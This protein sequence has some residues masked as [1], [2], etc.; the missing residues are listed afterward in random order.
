[1][2]DIGK[3]GGRLTSRQLL[4]REISALGFE[5][6]P[7]R[8]AGVSLVAPMAGIAANDERA[9]A[10][11]RQL[12]EAVSSNSEVCLRVTDAGGGDDAIGNWQ[13]CCERIRT[14]TDLRGVDSARLAV[15]MPAHLMPA[16][17]FSLISDSTLGSGP[18]YLILDSLQFEQHADDDI[19]RCA[20]SVWT[21]LWRHRS[22]PR[23]L[24]PVY[25]GIV[26]SG[27]PLLSAEVAAA[28]LPPHGL[29]VPDG[30][31]WL[32]F[33][34]L[35]TRYADADGRVDETLL[36]RNLERFLPLADELVDDLWPACPRQRRDAALNRR[37]AISISGFGDLVSRRGE[38]P[39]ELSCLSW[40]SELAAGVRQ[41]LQAES[42]QLAA[43]HEPVPALTPSD[44]TVEWRAGSSRE[45]W[46]T[47]W[48]DAL[49]KSAVRHRNLVVIS[50]YAVLPRE[51]RARPGYADLLPLIGHADAWSFANPH[52]FEGWKIG[53]F[54]RFHARA[55]AIIQGSNANSFVAA[56]V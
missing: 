51:A 36:S 25:G 53:A 31:A 9:A 46:Q 3:A 52:P 32:P 24:M 49:S 10:F 16:E 41:I 50:P 1:M 27:C 56:G 33:G 2:L 44:L 11:F 40:L 28:M 22:A 38:N 34:L 18:R 14:F 4:R 54:R 37:L 13:A 30:S 12:G 17:S 15:S 5:P 26:R 55:R 20:R 39:A 23:P 48:R 45:A 7:D 35:L 47:I 43:L 6:P 19:Q 21:F 29:Q 42:A 8:P